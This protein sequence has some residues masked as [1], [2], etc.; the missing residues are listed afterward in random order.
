MIARVGVVRRAGMDRVQAAVPAAT[1]IADPVATVPEA[2][3]VGRVAIVRNNRAAAVAGVIFVG[4]IGAVNGHARSGASQW[5]R[6]R[7]SWSR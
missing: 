4:M 3:L 1:R 6:C 7:T 5:C 2:G